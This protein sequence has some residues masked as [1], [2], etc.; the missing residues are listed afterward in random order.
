MS[1]NPWQDILVPEENICARRIDHAH[2]LDFFW[3]RDIYGNNLLILET[4]S[5]SVNIELP[6]VKGIELKRVRFDDNMRFILVLR[7]KSEW[8]IFLTLCLDLV[9]ST[10]SVKNVPDGM[11]I[12]VR[13]LLRW[14][15]F[16]K[17]S[18]LLMSESEVK[19]LIGEIYFL[20]RYLAPKFGLEPAINAWMGPDG[21]PQDFLLNKKAIEVK[22]T[23]GSNNSTIHITSVEQLTSQENVD[24]WLYVL[25]LT[26]GDN[27]A[28]AIT[29]PSIIKEISDQISASAFEK[30]NNKLLQLGYCYSESYEN[31]RYFILKDAF[32]KIDNEF[33]RITSECLK[34]GIGKV[35]Y[36]ISLEKCQSK[37]T[38]IQW[39]DNC[40]Y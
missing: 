9:N 18:R 32:Y 3:G 37:I 34:E 5:E 39:E 10:A 20:S 15:D 11:S 40:D 7:E 22:C 16:L 26:P 36:S 2:P 31:M 25:S 13:R 1:S 35:N 17:T 12:V 21:N 28:D 24:L 27:S 8:E 38:N 4:T 19:G 23:C 33:P 30:F 29:L 6:R 14:K